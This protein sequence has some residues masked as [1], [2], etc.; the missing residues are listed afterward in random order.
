MAMTR[1]QLLESGLFAS[2]AATIGLA[3]RL[4]EISVLQ[5]CDGAA[6]QPWCGWPHGTGLLLAANAAILAASPHNTQPWR[7]RI[8]DSR[9]DLFADTK[10]NIGTI[11]PLFREQ[12]IGTGCA[13]EN[14]VVAAV[15]AGRR[16]REIVYD[17]DP[18]TENIASIT[19]G[20]GTAQPSALYQAIPHRHTNRGPYLSNK[21]VPADLI[22]EMEALNLEADAIQIK[23]WT[24]AS[25]R[26]RIKELIIAAS[27]A[28]VA[29]HEQSRDSSRWYRATHAAIERH[30][31]GVTLDAQ[32]LSPI[33]TAVAKLMP[34]PSPSMADRVFL[35]RT[36][37]VHC[38]PGSIFGTLIA[39]QPAGKETRVHVG[40]LWQRM[41]LWAT[42]NGL[43]MQPLNQ[44]HERIDR[45]ATVQLPPRFTHDLAGIIGE[46][47]WAGLFTFRMGYAASPGRPSPRRDL[48]Q[49]LF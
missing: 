10:R 33:M 21:F 23:M 4:K 31:D 46:S 38:G 16:V 49:F 7:F 27:E 15:Y 43:A 36:K 1:R 17:S 47:D 13:L 19:F 22:R 14:L 24:D 48:A 12:Q 39:R 18:A 40:R 3:W 8:T 37:A 34:E 42:A 41:H 6:Y 30:R 32:G 2:G 44:I 29:D 20:A 35:E 5:P 45:E 25:S 9:V 11:D 26:E 28:I